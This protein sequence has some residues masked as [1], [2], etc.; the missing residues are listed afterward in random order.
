MTACRDR[1]GLPAVRAVLIMPIVPAFSLRRLLDGPFAGPF[2]FAAAVSS[3][4]GNRGWSA[5]GHLRVCPDS[6][7]PIPLG[8]RGTTAAGVPHKWAPIA[9]L[10]STGGSLFRSPHH[11]DRVGSIL[12]LTPSLRLTGAAPSGGSKSRS[13]CHSPAKPARQANLPG[14]PCPGRPA[15]RLGVA[16]L[17]DGAREARDR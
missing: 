6:A 2:I 14:Q 17:R 12:P 8:C 1:D 16:R 9:P 3:L 4:P 11:A 5:R 10:P 13:P 15:R 7:F